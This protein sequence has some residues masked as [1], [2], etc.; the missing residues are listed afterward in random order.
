MHDRIKFLQGNEACVEGALTAGASFYAGYPITPSS[1]IAEL[2]SIR[3]PAVGGVFIQM[4]DEIASMAAL[5]GAS[6]AGAKAFTATSGPGFSLMQ[7]NIGLAIMTE[8]PCVI[9]NVQRSGPSTGLATKPAQADVMQA[10]WGTHG[11]HAIIVLSPASVQECYELMIQAFNFAEE[12]RTPVIFLSDE[13]VGHMREKVILRDDIPIVNR[14]FPKVDPPEYRPYQPGEDGVPPLAYFGSD[15]IFHASSSMHD[16]TGYPN[17]VPDNAEKVIK[18]LYKKIYDHRD[19]IIITKEYETEDAEII[20]VSFG[21]SARSAREAVY[22]L[23]E[24]GYKAGLLQLNTLWPFP[25]EK[26]R[27]LA[28]R[29]KFMV[30]PEMNL[31]QIIS[32]VKRVVEAR[33]PVYGV[34]KVNG[35]IITPYEI[36][37][38]IKE[39]F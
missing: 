29:A 28:D 18:R 35:E 5:V 15:Y 9:I 17:N 23:R 12:F 31:G 14:K 32:E 20:L 26:V 30:V 33:I 27:Q 4:E 7:E 34:N 11:D 8:A 3:L 19:E 37:G 1:E 2:A 10:R 21:A 6:M 25:D 16:E 13:I 24:S 38:K 22:I 36:L 39:V